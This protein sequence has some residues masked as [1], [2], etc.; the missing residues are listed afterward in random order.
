MDNIKTE[1][2]TENQKNK[3]NGNYEISEELSQ[4]KS[5]DDKFCLFESVI[6]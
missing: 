4:I 5:F 2:T 1:N 6:I 3:L